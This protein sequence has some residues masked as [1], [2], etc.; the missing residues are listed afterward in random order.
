VLL[1]PSAPARLANPGAAAV[2]FSRALVRAFGE[3]GSSRSP[4]AAADVLRSTAAK[5]QG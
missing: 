3:A 4:E 2:D 5:L 1:D